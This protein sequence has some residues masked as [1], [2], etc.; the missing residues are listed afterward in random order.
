MKKGEVLENYK[1]VNSKL[2]ELNNVDNIFVYKSGVKYIPGIGLI[3]D[4]PNIEVLSQ[5]KTVIDKAF[6]ETNDNVSLDEL[7]ISGLEKLSN[8]SNVK[9]FLGLTKNTWYD[10]LKTKGLE[11]VYN[12]KV[13]TLKDLKNK[14]ELHLSTEDNFELEFSGLDIDNLLN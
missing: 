11:L 5:A 9:R 7:G 6:I 2:E 4:I 1:K 14:L 10:D 3:Q 12:N 13:K 8:S